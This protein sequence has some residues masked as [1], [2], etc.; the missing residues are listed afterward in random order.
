VASGQYFLTG[1]TTY[2]RSPKEWF[3]TRVDR[4]EVD[5]RT[6]DDYF[7]SLNSIDLLEFIISIETEFGF[8]FADDALAES[9]GRLLDQWA[10]FI[11]RPV[12]T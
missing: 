2:Y 4:P 1:S 12:S 3:P 11:Q 6:R 5:P 8:G 9:K 7:L 10:Q